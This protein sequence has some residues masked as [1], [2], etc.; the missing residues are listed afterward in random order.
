MGKPGPWRR[1]IGLDPENDMALERAIV[2]HGADYVSRDMAMTQGRV[3]RSL[4]CFA[5]A[6]DVR[7]EV[8]ARLG[9]GRLLYA[10]KPA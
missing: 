8:L 3:G 1:L 2:L 9:E 5:V 7:D 4:G 6:L 10:G